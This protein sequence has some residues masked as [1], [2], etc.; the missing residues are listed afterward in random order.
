MNFNDGFYLTCLYHTLLPYQHFDIGSR[1]APDRQPRRADVGIRRR[2]DVILLIGPTS[3]RRLRRPDVG[4]TS[5][6][7]LLPAFPQCNLMYR[8]ANVWPMSS[9]C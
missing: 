4:P 5:A 2:A 6:Q 3:G 1:S 9:Q 7:H 8:L